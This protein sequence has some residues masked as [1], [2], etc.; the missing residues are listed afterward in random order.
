MRE[1]DNKVEVFEPL[2]E[3]LDALFARENAKAMAELEAK[4]RAKVWPG[5][6]EELLGVLAKRSQS[7]ADALRAIH[8]RLGVIE[9][10]MGIS[11]G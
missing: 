5:Q 9:A 6:V 3:Q 8:D 7:Q 2:P 1:E 11:E 4:E 10:A